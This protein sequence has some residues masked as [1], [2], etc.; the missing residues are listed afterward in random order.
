MSLST[1]FTTA[2]KNLK[3]Y[4]GSNLISAIIEATKRESDASLVMEHL[5]NR[6]LNATT[7]ITYKVPLVY[8]IDA[9]VKKMRGTFVTELSNRLH[10]FFSI[11]FHVISDKDKLRLRAVLRSWQKQHILENHVTDP[12]YKEVQKWINGNPDRVAVAQGKKRIVPNTNFSANTGNLQPVGID[13]SAMLQS[14][15]RQQFQFQQQQFQFRQ[16]Q[17]SQMYMMN[18]GTFSTMIAENSGNGRNNNMQMGRGVNSHNNVILQQ[19]PSQFQPPPQQQFNAFPPHHPSR[20]L[21]HMQQQPPAPPPQQFNSIMSGI[22]I[23][24][25]GAGS[26]I[27]PFQT[28]PSTA[29]DTKS[30]TNEAEMLLNMIGLPSMGD[31]SISNDN[32]GIS[33]KRNDDKNDTTNET[34]DSVLGF[35]NQVKNT[36]NN[37]PLI[38]K[39]PVKDVFGVPQFILHV[40]RRNENIIEKLYGKFHYFCKTSGA[41]LSTEKEYNAH[42]DWV[43]KRKQGNPDVTSRLWYLSDKEWLSLRGS[44]NTNDKVDDGL[45][46]VNA[47]LSKK[48]ENRKVIADDNFK[49]CPISKEN[50]EL[51]Y[52]EEIENWVYKDA[53][54]PDGPGTNIFSKHCYTKEKA[55]ALKLKEKAKETE[56]EIHTSGQ[57]K[58]EAEEAELMKMRK[59][60][61]IEVAD[62]CGVSNKG[63]KSDI[64]SAILEFKKG[65]RNSKRKRSDSNGHADDDI[66]GETHDNKRGKKCT[67]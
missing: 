34:L 35:L 55:D 42:L 39:I 38:A 24:S 12:L 3:E 54:Q 59:Q 52:D 13:M 2:V 22:N 21:R 9:I 1:A 27:K 19:M 57:G 36:N 8:A 18:N 47:M 23:T 32:S 16:Q 31:D 49:I 25:N 29:S 53:I 62:E 6:L 15:Q 17:Q 58:L 4:P 66:L 67:T 11:T 44:G 60:E 48:L 51:L 45:A 14:Q 50:F 37:K 10:Q 63:T 43:F 33:K 28:L 46:L 7:P 64:V 56:T 30:N 65:G 20:Q 61:L 41:R 40:N 5:I 26:A